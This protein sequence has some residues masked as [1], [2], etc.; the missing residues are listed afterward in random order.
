MAS[1]S[2]TTCRGISAGFVKGHNGLRLFVVEEGKIL[3]LQAGHRLAG[4]VGYH[5]VE[6]NAA[7]AGRR[8][9]GWARGQGRDLR[10]GRAL[11]GDSR[12]RKPK[13]ESDQNFGPSAHVRLPPV[14]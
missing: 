9:R 6:D 12:K 2:K 4:A 10:R 1:T 8:R 7:I 3:L 13:A 5:H 14:S 11:P